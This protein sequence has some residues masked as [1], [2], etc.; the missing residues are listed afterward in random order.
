MKDCPWLSECGFYYVVILNSLFLLKHN[1]LHT[2]SFEF[3]SLIL[4]E[5]K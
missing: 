4:I 1:F 3:F 2:D 5:R